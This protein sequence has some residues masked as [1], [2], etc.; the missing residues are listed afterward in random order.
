M[1]HYIFHRLSHAFMRLGMNLFLMT[2]CVPVFLI[3]LLIRRLEIVLTEGRNR[4]IR[5]M[6]EEVGLQVY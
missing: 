3:F 1:G 4:Q 5:K 2:Y 6:A